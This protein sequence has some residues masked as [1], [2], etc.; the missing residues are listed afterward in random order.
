MPK[1]KDMH[2]SYQQQESGRQWLVQPIQAF[3][4]ST[5][6]NNLGDISYVTPKTRTKIVLEKQRP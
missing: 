2:P 4:Q 1:A 6:T 3:D 5:N